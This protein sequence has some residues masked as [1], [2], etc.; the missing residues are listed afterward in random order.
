MGN[1][2]HDEI[3]IIEYTDIF[4]VRNIK[5]KCTQCGTF[6]KQAEKRETVSYWDIDDTSELLDAK[7]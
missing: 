7:K 3:E 1:C 2:N 5:K 4:G 6:I